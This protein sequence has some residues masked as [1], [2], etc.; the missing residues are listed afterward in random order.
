M[1]A[2]DTKVALI[3]RLDC[4]VSE[5]GGGGR[6]SSSPGTQCVVC[7]SLANFL[8]SGCQKIYYCT[9]KCQ[10]RLSQATS[11]LHNRLLST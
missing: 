4:R 1:Q 6:S 8:C 7:H 5:A 9:V 2:L 10:V 11:L 3:P